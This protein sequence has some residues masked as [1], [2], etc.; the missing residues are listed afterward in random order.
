MGINVA[1][2]NWIVSDVTGFAPSVKF[3]FWHDWAAFHCLINEDKI[4]KYV[5]IAAQSIV[6]EGYLILGTFAQNRPQNY[7]EIETKQYL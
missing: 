1:K 6:S 2:V 5:H 7:C 4:E 3:D